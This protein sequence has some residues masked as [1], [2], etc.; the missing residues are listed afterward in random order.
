M[1]IIFKPLIFLSTLL[2]FNY[3]SADTSNLKNIYGNKVSSAASIEIN[4]TNLIDV[5]HAERLLVNLSFFQEASEKE[6]E[7]IK[8]KNKNRKKPKYKSNVTEI[9]SE[10]SN[11]VVFIGSREKGAIR[12]VGSGFIISKNGKKI[13]T[14]WHVIRNA[15][16]VHV[17]LKPSKMVDEDY[18][19]NEV[20]SYTAKI[21]NINKKKDLALLEVE[22]IP[23]KIKPISYGSFDDLKIG[24]ELFAIGH[25]SGLLWT[26]TDGRVSQKREDYKWRYKSSRH[27][28]DV[29]QTSTAI[30][31]GNSG[32][33][34]FNKK[35]QLVGVNTFTAEG[36]NLNFAIS[37][38]DL[39]AFLDEKPKP[40]IKKKNNNKW[41]KKKDKGSTWI[42]KKE[43]KQ[44]K[45]GS[46]SFEN[47][48]EGDLNGN[49]V[50]DTWGIDENNNGIF[51]IVYSDMNENGKVEIIAIDKNEDKN[52]E[53][54]VFDEDEN[55]NPDIAEIDEDEDGNADVVA[56]DYNQ[57][58]EWDK[59]KPVG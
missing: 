35:K 47:A 27:N 20:D 26:F 29:I 4:D 38:D 43:K 21:I 41:I 16:Q 55:G 19:I 5:S 36:E 23:Y 13:V 10:Y 37:V 24:E 14:N 8:K 40:F 7:K 33:P 52:F 57:D 11:S 44:N 56:Y 12:G 2:F 42:K 15:D 31:P 25:P 1:K 50:I 17:W 3:L 9:F 22:G 46:L 59:F 39:I 54:I 32:G 6:G 18:L 45:K 48:K 58:G 49:G 53:I 51:E 30:N 28:A 34:L